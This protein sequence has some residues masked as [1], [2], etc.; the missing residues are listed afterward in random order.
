MTTLQTFL[1]SIEPLP[2][3]LAARLLDIVREKTLVRREHLIRA[4]K[5]CRNIYFIRAGLLRCYYFNG[6][7]EVSSWFLKEGDVCIDVESFFEQRVGDE[8]IQALEDSV[9][10]YISHE[11]LESLYRDFPSFNRWGRLLTQKYYLLC[12]RRMK[13]LWME[14]ATEKYKWIQQHDPDILQRVQGKYLASHL[15][16]T[17]V[18]LSRLRNE[19]RGS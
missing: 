4:G 3:A 5:I 6:S 2:D 8:N 14:N 12:Y 19:R 1:A 17:N 16:I 10:E 18:M 13:G 11:Q 7:K 9:V 15:G